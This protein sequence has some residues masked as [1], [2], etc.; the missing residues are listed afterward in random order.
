MTMHDTT[1]VLFYL[2]SILRPGLY[3]PQIANLARKSGAAETVSCKDLLFWLGV[4]ASTA[5]YAVINIA[6]W[7]L[8]ATAVINMAGCLS[9]LAITLWR[10]QRASTGIAL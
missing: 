8:F 1:F 3:V 7:V 10:R 4:H 2:F 6:D 5:A 9:V